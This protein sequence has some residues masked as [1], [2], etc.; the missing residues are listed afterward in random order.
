M[1]ASPEKAVELERR[2]A[3]L[4]AR[5]PKHSVP[6]AMLIQLEELEEALERIKAEASHEKARGVT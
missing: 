2:I 4:K 3:D 6:P 5:L 1:A